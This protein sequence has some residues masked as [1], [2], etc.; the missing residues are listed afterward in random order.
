M[1]VLV[2]LLV[3]KFFMDL[4]TQVRVYSTSP[5]SASL[6]IFSSL[7]ILKQLF[8]LIYCWQLM[9]FQII[10]FSYTCQVTIMFESFFIVTNLVYIF[11][12]KILDTLIKVQ[13]L[14][15]IKNENL[16]LLNFFF[17]TNHLKNCDGTSCKCYICS[18]I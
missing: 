9:K 4:I 1:E 17:N 12:K 3:E 15:L 5:L 13:C 11:S 18:E 14:K 10:F 8:S 16:K 7:N 6:G 2:R